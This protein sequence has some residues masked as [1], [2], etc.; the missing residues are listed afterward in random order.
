M[1]A[2]LM[3][4]TGQ[5]D[6]STIASVAA[7]SDPGTDIITIQFDDS[8]DKSTR[9]AALTRALEVLTEEGWL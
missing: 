8:D 2:R 6:M 5:Q 1:A 3:A 4:V 9:R 7:G